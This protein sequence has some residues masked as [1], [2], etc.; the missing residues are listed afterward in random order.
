M[1]SE[2]LKQ[3]SRRDNKISFYCNAYVY[4]FK[5]CYLVLIIQSQ[6]CLRHLQQPMKVGSQ[7]SLYQFFT[8]FLWFRSINVK[9]P[10]AFSILK[11]LHSDDISGTPDDVIFSARRSGGVLEEQVDQDYNIHNISKQMRSVYTVMKLYQ[12]GFLARHRDTVF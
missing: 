3:T 12:L 4:N 1:C 7:F 5:V 11:Y 6:F 10:S 2:V 9:F 8:C